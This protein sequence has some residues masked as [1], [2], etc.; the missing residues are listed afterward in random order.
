M[1]HPCFEDTEIFP[2]AYASQFEHFTDESAHAVENSSETPSSQVEKTSMSSLQKST[3]CKRTVQELLNEFLVQKTVYTKAVTDDWCLNDILFDKQLNESPNMNTLEVNS[4]AQIL[5]MPENVLN[6]DLL[7]FQQSKPEL[8]VL[9]ER[10]AQNGSATSDNTISS[11]IR[12]TLPKEYLPIVSVKRLSDEIYKKCI[13]K[14][15]VVMKKIKNLSPM[16]NKRISSVTN[17][18][19]VTIEITKSSDCSNITIRIISGGKRNA[20]K[21]NELTIKKLKEIVSKYLEN[22]Q[23]KTNPFCILVPS[24]IFGIGKKCC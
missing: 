18:K 13:N 3:K 22:S 10:D 6:R 11:K 4:D 1:N 14:G 24:K 2:C 15:Y 21:L 8:S 9:N 19:F 7:N 20:F 23:I 16:K 5:E 17:K 12:S